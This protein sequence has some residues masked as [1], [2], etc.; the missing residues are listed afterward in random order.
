[1]EI[2]NEEGMEYLS[3]IDNNSID[4]IITPHHILHQQ[5][6]GWEIFINK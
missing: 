1:M 5:K 6:Q 2:K 3:H 4:L